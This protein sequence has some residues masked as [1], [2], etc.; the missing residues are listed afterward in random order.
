MFYL[1]YLYE[2]I[3]GHGRQN[4][5]D[6]LKFLSVS[7]LLVKCKNVSLSVQKSVHVLIDTCAQPPS[8]NLNN[9]LST[10]YYY[11]YSTFFLQNV[12]DQRI[13]WNGLLVHL[14]TFEADTVV[15]MIGHYVMDFLIAHHAKMRIL[16]C[17]S[18]IKR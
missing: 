2:V 5:L 14:Q 18:S 3:A 11:I 17:A 13:A 12:L 9:L 7:A 15:L 1:L 6:P 8:T 10:Y 4:Q 16:K